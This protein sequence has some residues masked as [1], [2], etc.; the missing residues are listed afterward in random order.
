M[1]EKNTLAR[2]YAL[3][4]FKQAQEEG[5]LDMWL[6]ML[7]FL[8][9][10]ASEPSMVEI[11]KNPRVSKPNLTTLILDIVKGSLSRTGENFVRVVIDAGRM[12]VVQEILQLFEKEFNTFKKRN[13]IEVTSAYP[14]AF[15]HQQSIKAA[16][17]KRLGLNVEIS[18]TIDESL[19]GGVVVRVGDVV[20]DMSL[21]GRLTQ[22]GLELI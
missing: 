18:V 3:A 2:P 7:R 4:A 19:I 10:V 17:T 1:A 22:L 9:E 14:L 5:K 13:R 12:E 20:I 16:M 11:I 6:G 21:R 15:A 8:S